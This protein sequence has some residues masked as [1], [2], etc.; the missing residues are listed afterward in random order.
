[1]RSRFSTDRAA[2][3]GQLII[4]STSRHALGIW[5]ALPW[6]LLIV[7]ISFL[8][9][10]GFHT[11]TPPPADHPFGLTDDHVP[12]AVIMLNPD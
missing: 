2:E 10:L 7:F 12:H 1:M 5:E 9:V 11:E 6:P 3:T 4:R 8:V